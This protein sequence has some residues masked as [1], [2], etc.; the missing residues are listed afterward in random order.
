MS[1]FN[2]AFLENMKTECTSLI[3]K[4]D[5]L[6][7]EKEELE[8]EK[9]AITEERTRLIIRAV[10]LSR[11]KAALMQDKTNGNH[12]N[13]NK[14]E[15]NPRPNERKGKKGTTGKRNPREWKWE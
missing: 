14:K 10:E 6:M 4:F 3:E 2:K 12:R 5:A 7:K 8:K 11:L 1:S 13:P 15:E 9:Q